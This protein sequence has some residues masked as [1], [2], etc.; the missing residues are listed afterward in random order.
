M[1]TCILFKPWCYTF[2]IYLKAYE[3]A[4]FLFHCKLKTTL[5]HKCCQLS[6]TCNMLQINLSTVRHLTDWSALNVCTQDHVALKKSWIQEHKG[7]SLQREC[8]SCNSSRA[9]DKRRRDREMLLHW[10]MDGSL[11]RV[12]GGDSTFPDWLCSGGWLSVCTCVCVYV[13]VCLEGATL[14]HTVQTVYAYQPA[15]SASLSWAVYLNLFWENST[16]LVGISP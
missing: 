15:L 7:W 6:L 16:W 11:V 2:K 3:L 9:I 1:L 4:P 12:P 5:C 8:V 14:Q 10:K 13:W